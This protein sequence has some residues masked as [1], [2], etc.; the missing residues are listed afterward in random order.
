[1]EPYLD[2][3]LDVRSSQ[4]VR[5]HLA[6]CAHCAKAFAGEE[7]FHRQ[8]NSRLK[9]G[10]RTAPVWDVVEEAVTGA[11]VEPSQTAPVG[12]HQVPERK[13]KVSVSSL[14]WWLWPSPRYYA[15]LAA[16]WLILLPLHL[17]SRDPIPA[18]QSSSASVP[19][20][21]R[22]VLLEQR[23]MLAELL[24]APRQ[25]QTQESRRPVVRPSRSEKSIKNI[26]V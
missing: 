8:L 11:T 5:E 24:G 21:A 2:S 12:N 6:S 17:A 3:E 20:A 13:S 16:L 14:V 1:M 22:T 15:G 7:Q 18:R 25:M 9:H 19:V 4:E 26:R 10:N 23:R